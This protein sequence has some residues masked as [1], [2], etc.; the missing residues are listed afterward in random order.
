[1]HNP[2]AVLENEM[3]KVLWDFE[4]Q[5]NSLISLRRLDQMIVKK[6]KKKSCRIEAFAFPALHRVKLKKSEKRNKY[7]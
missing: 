2:E 1:M 3:Y 5:T 6:R 7:L 4:I